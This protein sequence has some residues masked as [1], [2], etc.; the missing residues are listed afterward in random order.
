MTENLL[1]YDTNTVERSVILNSIRDHTAMMSDAALRILEYVN[2]R[3]VRTFLTGNPVLD[4]A[5]MEVSC[6]QDL[7]LTKALRRITNESELM[8]VA[9]AAISPMEY[10]TPEIRACALLL[11]PYTT[12]QLRQVTRSFMSAYFSNS[13]DDNED[14]A[15]RI[16]GRDGLI[17]IPCRN[18]YYIEVREK[19]LYIRL[20]DR[21]YSK[22]DS[23]ENIGASLP[24]Y[25]MQCH[26]SYIFNTRHIEKVKLSDGTI[27]LEHDITVPLARSY[28]QKIKE[29]INGRQQ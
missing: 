20:R 4:L 5:V 26:R 3:D 13:S 2:E 25:F 29:F 8:L 11:R 14:D 21:E 16:D 15:I 17:T 27:Y 7:D 23:L 24:D 1:I 18:I 9:D 28:R 22:Y 10:L 12:E 6:G 19:R